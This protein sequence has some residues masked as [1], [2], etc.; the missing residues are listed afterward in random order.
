M[1]NCRSN[2]SVV[3]EKNQSELDDRVPRDLP[4]VEQEART[5]AEAAAREAHDEALKEAEKKIEGLFHVIFFKIN[6]IAF[7]HF[8]LVKKDKWKVIY[9]L[10][11]V[12]NAKKILIRNFHKFESQ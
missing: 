9:Q 4:S 10:L 3:V 11:I 2:S 1:G 5:R 7:L 8:Y 12:R 6:I